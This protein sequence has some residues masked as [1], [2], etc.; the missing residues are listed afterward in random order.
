M[1]GVESNCFQLAAGL[2]PLPQKNIPSASERPWGGQITRKLL[3][4]EFGGGNLI[5]KISGQSALHTQIFDSLG[6]GILEECGP[7]FYKPI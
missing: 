3:T 5:T 4:N 7:R 2:N 1:R 6:G